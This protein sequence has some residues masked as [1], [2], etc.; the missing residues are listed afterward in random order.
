M[1]EQGCSCECSAPSYCTAFAACACPRSQKSVRL[2][3]GAWLSLL[4]DHIQAGSA[5][6]FATARGLVG[7][8]QDVE[9]D[10]ALYYED[11]GGSSTDSQLKPAMTD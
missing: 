2:T 10:G 8:S 1:Q 6:V 11:F 5:E 7:L 9:T 4:Y 3:T